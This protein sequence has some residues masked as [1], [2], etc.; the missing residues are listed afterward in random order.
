MLAYEKE[1]ELDLSDSTSLGCPLAEMRPFSG[2]ESRAAL[3][4]EDHPVP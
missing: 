4:D 1:I 2:S 3:S